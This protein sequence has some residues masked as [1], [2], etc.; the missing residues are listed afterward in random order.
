MGHRCRVVHQSGFFNTV[1]QAGGWIVNEDKTK[2]GH[3]ESESLEGLRFWTDL[4]HVHKHR[5]PWLR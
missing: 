2:A 5:P 1:Y 3:A 4:I